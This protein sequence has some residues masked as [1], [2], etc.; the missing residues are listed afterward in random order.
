MVLKR[1]VKAP[2][3]VW[4]QGGKPSKLPSS[5]KKPKPRGID[6]NGAYYGIINTS[7]GGGRNGTNPA[8]ASKGNKLFGITRTPKKA[9]STLTAKVK[10]YT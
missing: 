7:R 3:A 10:R 6:P 2:K 9:Q 4:G 1:R 5:T 8:A